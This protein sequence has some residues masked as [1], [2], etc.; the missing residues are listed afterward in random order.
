MPAWIVRVLVAV[1][2]FLAT[3]LF[4]FLTMEGY[5][6]FGGGEKDIFLS[7]PL[8]LWSLIFLVS[9][10]IAWWRKSTLRRAA[11]ISAIVAT[12]VVV[13]IWVSLLA[14]VLKQSAHG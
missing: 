5:L 2:P 1:L 6:S 4:T 7:V 8:L 14:Y 3:I 10:L 13:L 12:A 9:S 11:A